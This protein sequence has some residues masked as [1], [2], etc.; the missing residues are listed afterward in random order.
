VT[1]SWFSPQTVGGIL[2]VLAFGA[3]CVGDIRRGVIAF[4]AAG[5]I[6]NVQIGAFGGAE[7]VQGLL[8]VEALASV[9]FVAW[10]V[11]RRQR[12]IRWTPFDTTLLLLFPSSV[13]SLIFG[14]VAYDESVALDHMKLS[15]SLGQVLLT[16]WPIATYFVVANAVDD[17]KTID[18]IRKLIVLLALP[19]LVLMFVPSA[20]SYVAWSTSF[21]LPA[22][23]FCFVECF[24][25]QS[26]VR[27]AGLLVVALAPV[28]YGIEMGKAFYYA[29][30]IVSSGVI[31]CLMARRAM[32]VLIPIAL[33][34]YV[35]AVPLASSSLTPG[36]FNHLVEGEQEQQ[37]LGG[38]GG[39]DQLILD[40][41]GIWSRSPVLGVGPGNNYPYML[42][43]SSLG[44]AHN[45]YVNIL[46]ELGAVGLVCFAVFSF[47]AL[48]MGLRLWQTARNPTHRALVLAWIGIF[49]GFLVGGFFGDFML[50]SIRNAGLELFA[51]FYVQWIVL[52]LIV[53]A[54]AIERRYTGGV[55]TYEYSQSS[56]HRI[57]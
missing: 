26:N 16:M 1:V 29:Y 30:V 13:V 37:S 45:Q 8:P 27:R 28:V 42:K 10:L 32:V 51:E 17:T 5:C 53:S 3:L 50:P 46:M 4:T 6:R 57:E 43:Y 38:T 12:P 36:F 2:A 22:S 40:G 49:S 39:R 19:S 47:Q 14:F 23:S 31:T 35:I 52:G 18:A 11:T 48:R 9:M 34:T 15:V 20:W 41:L 21:A 44:T 55:R 33:A 24:E 7:M 25:R 56:L 54:A